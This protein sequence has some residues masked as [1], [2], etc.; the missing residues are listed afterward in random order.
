MD[1]TAVIARAARKLSASVVW[2]RCRGQAWLPEAGLVNF[3][4]GLLL[5]GPVFPVRTQGAILPVLQALAAIPPGHVLVVH[6]AA[7]A[8]GRALLGDIIMCA[9]VH[10][11]VAGIVCFGRV[12]D[13]K[14]AEPL[15]MPLWALGATP[16]AAPVGSAA[17]AV[18]EAVAVAGGRIEPGD[19]VFGDRDG[20]V[21]VPAA[22]ARL[23]IKAAELKDRKEAAFKQRI[24][25]G[26]VL[27]EMMNLEG[28]L[29]RHEPLRVD[30]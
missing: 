1:R 25:D 29:A 23:V 11:R 4:P 30:F 20:M 6:D 15:G 13:V 8:P 7:A 18:P 24:R 22:H 14:D 5:A 16:A 10:Q 19:W 12:R 26:E 2:D 3:A 28:H 17:A 27:H 9:A 21:I